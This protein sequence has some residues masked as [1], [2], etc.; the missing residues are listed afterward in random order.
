MSRDEREHGSRT[1]KTCRGVR[2]S[3]SRDKLDNCLFFYKTFNGLAC[4]S[5]IVI[6]SII[7]LKLV[8]NCGNPAVKMLLSSAA[9]I[10][11]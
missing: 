9:N 8:L 2:T 10:R 3:E 4:A 6:V 7:N 1:S 5:L 11:W